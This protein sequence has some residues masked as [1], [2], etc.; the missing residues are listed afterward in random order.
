MKELEYLEIINDTLSDTTLLG[1]DCAYLKEFD[2]C[3]TQDTL[4]EGIHF[5]LDTTTPF[6]LGQ[7]AVNVNLSDLAA[8]G[9]KPL[10]L[11]ISLSL[12]PNTDNSF[13]QEFYK[14]VDKICTTHG[15][16]VAGG[17]LTGS[18]RVFIS[19]CALGK[20]YN[21]VSVSRNAAKPD[22]IIVTTG[23]HGDSAGGLKLLQQGKTAPEILIQKHL[24]AQAKTEESNIIMQTAE[25]SGLKQLAMMDTSDG[26]GDAIYKLS[27]GCGFA[28]DIDF[29]SVPVSSELKEAFPD[30]YKDL[31]LW[32]GE[33]FELLFTMPEHAYEKLDRTRFFKIGYVTKR[34]FSKEEEEIFEKKSF[35]HFEDK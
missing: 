31:V 25:E 12:P 29:D 10:Y 24:I 22:D 19:V 15:V 5:T 8:S 27:K 30:E 28:F 11:T 1:D 2:I 33:D 18:D 23:T 4:V 9:S 32:G 3:I 6:E 17:D 21:S 16:K 7:K 14:G 26:L 35:K 20:K 34:H 13:L